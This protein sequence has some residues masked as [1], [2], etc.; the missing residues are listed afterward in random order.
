[1]QT[2]TRTYTSM[3]AH[4][5]LILYRDHLRKGRMKPEAASATGDGRLIFH[6]TFCS[7]S[8]CSILRRI[9]SLV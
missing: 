2:H 1:M 9:N 6:N 7:R 8:I 3:H 4:E 5:R